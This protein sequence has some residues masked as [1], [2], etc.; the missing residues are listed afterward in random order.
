MKGRYLKNRKFQSIEGLDNFL[1][2]AVYDYNYVRPHYKHAPKTPGE[3]YYE[4]KLNF[5][6]EKR[7]ARSLK[8][9]VKKN[10]EN[11]CTMC[12][13]NNSGTKVSPASF[14]GMSS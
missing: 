4:V 3:A 5:D 8:N 1:S 7:K 10:V 9:R 13:L 2:K 11:A 6:V 12:Q 14:S